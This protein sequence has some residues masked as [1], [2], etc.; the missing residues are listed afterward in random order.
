[1]PG[2]AAFRRMARATTAIL[3]LGLTFCAIDAIAYLQSRPAGTLRGR[4]G[5]MHVYQ[6]RQPF[7]P[8]WFQAG[9]DVIDAHE[10]QLAD[11]TIACVPEGAWINAVAGLAWPMRDTQWM[12]FCQDWIAE[13]LDRA[14]PD[15]LLVMKPERIAELTRI[16]PMIDALYIPI[17]TNAR[18]MTLYQLR[19]ENRN[20]EPFSEHRESIP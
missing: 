9:L 4:N 5:L 17:D 15:F 7:T 8:Q 20:R 13:D 14:P 18:G 11:R 12:P 2:P 10:T 16:E 3:L 1:L 19:P 6:R